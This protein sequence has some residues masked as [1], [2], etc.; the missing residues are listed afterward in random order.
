MSV[1]CL[2]ALA[3]CPDTL[4]MDTLILGKARVDVCSGRTSC[5]YCFYSRKCQSQFELKERE[6]F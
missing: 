5:V 3:R 4:I 1:T 2:E 6:S